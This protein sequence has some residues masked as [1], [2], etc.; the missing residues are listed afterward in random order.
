LVGSL[1]VSGLTLAGFVAGL[2]AL[3]T[4]DTAPS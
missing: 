3:L 2:F 4:L 1:S